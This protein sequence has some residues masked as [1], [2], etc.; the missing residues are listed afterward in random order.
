MDY[1]LAAG[2]DMAADDCIMLQCTIPCA[3]LTGLGQRAIIPLQELS[4]VQNLY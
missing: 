2:G 1:C 4:D 3:K